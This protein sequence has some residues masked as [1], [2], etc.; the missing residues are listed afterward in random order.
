METTTSLW[1]K[2]AL[3]GGRHRRV[4]AKTPEIQL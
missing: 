3:R 2:R 1:F 4:D